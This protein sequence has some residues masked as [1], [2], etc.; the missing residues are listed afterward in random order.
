M[1][2]QNTTMSSNLTVRDQFFR[3]LLFLAPDLMNTQNKLDICFRYPNNASLANPF[4][5]WFD[6]SVTYLANDGEYTTVRLLKPLAIFRTVK[7]ILPKSRKARDSYDW[8]FVYLLVTFCRKLQCQLR[9]RNWQCWRGNFQFWIELTRE[10][11]NLKWV[12]KTWN[13]TVK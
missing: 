4:L 8:N 1:Y 11:W 9:R 7:N 13:N 10:F 12:M 6:V 2:S 5:T 3:I